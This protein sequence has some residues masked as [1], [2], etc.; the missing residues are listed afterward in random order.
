MSIYMIIPLMAAFGILGYA[1]RSYQDLRER[2]DRIYDLSYDQ[3]R[4][5]NMH[6]RHEN[7]TYLHEI[8][9]LQNETVALRNEKNAHEANLRLLL[10]EMDKS[11]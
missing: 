5:K 9:T 2:N 4:T 10:S 7:E 8:L 1:V 3:L 11:S 6:L